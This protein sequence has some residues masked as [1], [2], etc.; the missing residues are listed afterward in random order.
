MHS[1]SV[2][3][4]EP[5][6]NSRI[7]KIIHRSPTLSNELLDLTPLGRQEDWEQPPGRSNTTA[8]GWVRNHDSYEREDAA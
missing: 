2:K 7:I 3:R 1:R 6:I 4:R 5:A 8:Q